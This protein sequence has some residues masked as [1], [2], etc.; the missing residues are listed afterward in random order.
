MMINLEAQ[1]VISTPN[2]GFS[3]ACASPEF[4]TYN[5]TFSFSPENALSTSNQ[6]VL[7]LSDP[8]GSFD[9]PE[10]IFE[11]NPGAVTA[12]PATLTFSLPESTAGENYRIRVKATSPVATSTPSQPFAAYYKLQDEPFTINNLIGSG[13]YCPG[14][15]YLLTIDNPGGPMNNSPLQYPSLTFNWFREITST[16]AELVATGE[17]LSVNEPG[18]YFVE[19]NYGTC[20]SNSFSNR[21]TITEADD[22]NEFTISSSL[23]NPYCASEGATVLSAI[24]GQSYQWFRD[25][26]LINGATSQTLET[27]ESG[28]YTVNVNLGECSADASIT[29]ET[30]GF[31]ASI[32]ADEVNTLEEDESLWVTVDTDAQNP[33]FQWFKNNELIEGET[34]DFIEI[35]SAGSYKVVISQTVECI[36][37]VELTF[38][39][40]EAFPDVDSIPN[41]ISPNGDGI[42]DTWILP[43][44]FTIGTGTEIMIIS[45]NGDVVLKTTEYQNNWPTE[46]LEFSNVNPLYYY[47]ITPPNQSEQK[48]TITI[49]K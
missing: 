19:T 18:T 44:A 23:G 7:E 17:S 37:S 31:A 4:N 1:V 11:S 47:I 42:N 32:D 26:Q 21:V 30:T 40:V 20:T 14:G 15:S 12:S 10:V 45:V 28:E 22:S 38:V 3:Q 16:T 9:T 43:Q 5:V 34:F 8:S 39:V 46:A 41:V 29:L 35:T 2:L 25:G 48:G 13:V 36:A 33:E 49:I 6:F 24:N 27:N